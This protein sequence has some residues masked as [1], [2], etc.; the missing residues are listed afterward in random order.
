M[1]NCKLHLPKHLFSDKVC[2]KYTNIDNADIVFQELSNY[3]YTINNVEVTV[4]TCRPEIIIEKFPVSFISN[5]DN[6]V[7][8]ILN[9]HQNRFQSQHLTLNQLLYQP[10]LNG[11]GELARTAIYKFFPTS[12]YGKLLNA[13]ITYVYSRIG[14]QSKDNKFCPIKITFSVHHDD[15]SRPNWID[16]QTPQAAL[17]EKGTKQEI[18]ALRKKWMKNGYPRCHPDTY[19]VPSPIFDEKTIEQLRV[20]YALFCARDIREWAKS[21]NTPPSYAITVDIIT[22]EPMVS[23]NPVL[24]ELDSTPSHPS[25]VAALLFAL[26]STIGEGFLFSKQVPGLPRHAPHR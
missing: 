25:A 18:K 14:E 26:P 7:E 16:W 3:T 11:F 23:I 19:L 4:S 21:S 12:Y 1:T 20:I 22:C 15:H 24:P 17:E 2:Q 5:P 8:Y 10:T 13:R 6:P 9:G